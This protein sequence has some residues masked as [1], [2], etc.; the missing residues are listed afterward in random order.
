[1]CV[2]SS[3]HNPY[4]DSE[5]AQGWAMGLI[6]F[7]ML[8]LFIWWWRRRKKNENKESVPEEGRGQDTT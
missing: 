1:L 4:D 5:L 6:T 8:M 2:F 7:T 3:Y